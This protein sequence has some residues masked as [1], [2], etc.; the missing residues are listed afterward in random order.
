MAAPVSPAPAPAPVDAWIGRQNEAINLV[1]AY[2][3][4]GT[5]R[6]V[7]GQAKMILEDMHE[8]ELLHAAETGERLYLPD[9][10]A[11]QALREEGP[12]YRVYLNFSALQASGDRAQT[13][14]CQFA[15]DL[16][17]KK[18]GSDD[19]ASRRDFLEAATLLTHKHD[20]LADEIE[21]LLSGV[22]LLNKHKLRAVL[23]HKSRQ[24]KKDQKAIQV[25]VD[26]ARARVH[27]AIIYFRTRHPEK[28]L[29]NVAHAY[30]FI[31]VLKGDL[32]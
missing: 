13:R 25:S 30:N 29:Q 22:D 11:W 31:P 26:A 20:P 4:P 17:D 21:A 19:S 3:I 12:R 5:K 23:A 18:V 8:K 27:R 24:S 14:S 15:A 1:M 32:K 28:A 16:K 9:K 6:T 2:P 10:I 7:G